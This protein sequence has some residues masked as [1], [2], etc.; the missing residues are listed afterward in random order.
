MDEPGLA[1]NRVHGGLLRLCRPGARPLLAVPVSRINR[2]VRL[3]ALRDQSRVYRAGCLHRHGVEC[4]IG[5]GLE[6]GHD[7]A[8]PVCSGLHG[9]LREKA[10]HD[11]ATLTLSHDAVEHDMNVRRRTTAGVVR[12][13]APDHDLDD[14][15]RW[16]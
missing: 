16:E 5:G 15:V 11:L 13:E 10:G 3:L 14:V 2:D 6:S 12:L 9:A 7:G 4:R 8:E 1:R